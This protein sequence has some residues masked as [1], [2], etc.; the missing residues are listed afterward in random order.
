MITLIVTS[1]ELDI[2]SAAALLVFQPEYAEKS[3]DPSMV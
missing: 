2:R 1:D 3:I